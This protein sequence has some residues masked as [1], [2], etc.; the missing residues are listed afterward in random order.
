MNVRTNNAK[1]CNL[2]GTNGPQ[3]KKPIRKVPAQIRDALDV[4]I[5]LVEED[6]VEEARKILGYHDEPLKGERK[7]QRSMVVLSAF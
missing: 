4:W 7:G 1:F 6:G 5:E 2:R 3:A